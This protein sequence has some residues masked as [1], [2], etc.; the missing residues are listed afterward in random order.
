M[1]IYE[2]VCVHRYG[3]QVVP[4]CV[5]VVG[6]RHIGIFGTSFLSPRSNACDG[7]RPKKEGVKK[8]YNEFDRYVVS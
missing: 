3:S 2:C 7:V 6:C 4:E 1:F 8:M 5:Y